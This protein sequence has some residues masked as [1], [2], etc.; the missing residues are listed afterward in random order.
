MRDHNASWVRRLA[1]V[2]ILGLLTAAL[3]PSPAAAQNVELALDVNCKN[4]NS[5]DDWGDT[6]DFLGDIF[7]C[8]C[9]NHTWQLLDIA[10]IAH[11]GRWQSNNGMRNIYL[12]IDDSDGVALAA[13]FKYRTS[14]G[15]GRGHMMTWIPPASIHTGEA[16]AKIRVEE[17]D[18]VI[19]SIGRPPI[20]R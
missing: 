7:L 11:G 9:D 6:S 16:D 3:S 14:K 4:L 8:L 15:R 10:G 17:T 13:A 12:Q 2:T 5:D 19:C 18:P 20:D 1:A